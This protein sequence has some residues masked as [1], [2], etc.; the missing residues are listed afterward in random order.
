KE[1][2]AQCFR[3]ALTLGCGEHDL[4]LLGLLAYREREVCRWVDGAQ[5]ARALR[6]AIEALGEEEDRPLAAFP[7]LALFD[8]PA[9]HLRAA[10][11]TAR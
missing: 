11:V 4:N 5:D 10:Q 2:A 7:N 9:L 1:E 6:D 3:T 8:D